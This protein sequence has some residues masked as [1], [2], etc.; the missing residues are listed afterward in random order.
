MNEKK[1]LK[2]KA[3][4]NKEKETIFLTLKKK[5]LNF[6][7]KIFFNVNPFFLKKFIKRKLFFC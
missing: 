1:E 4:Q 3:K 6:A 7:K 5:L 2:E